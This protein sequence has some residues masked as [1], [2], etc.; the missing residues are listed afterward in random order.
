MEFVEL[1]EIPAGMIPLDNSIIGYNLTKLLGIQKY[2]PPIPAQ[3]SGQVKG[4]FPSFIPKTDQERCQNLYTEI[5]TD[6]LDE[7]YEVTT[8]LDGTSC[9]IYIRDGQVGVCGRNWE[10]TETDTNTLWRCAR[11]QG[12]IDAL[13]ALYSAQGRNIA[14]QGEVIGEGIQGNQ[15]QIKGQKF[16]IFDIYDIANRSYL[17]AFSRASM[18]YQLRQLCPE[19]DIEKVP[20]IEIGKVL[21][22]HQ[23]TTIDQLLKY[24]EGPSLNPNVQ[25]EGVVFKSTFSDFTFKAISNTWLLKNQ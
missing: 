25:R 6:H 19:A 14:L 23:F 1:L 17:N 21:K 3:L 11:D 22:D 24:A 10:L 8:K 12:I 15:E 20:L 16:F 2:E 5:F 13:E 18:V 9:T 7:V 4:N